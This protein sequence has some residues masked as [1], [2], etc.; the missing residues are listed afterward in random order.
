V[1]V[2]FAAFS[3]RGVDFSRISVLGSDAQELSGKTDYID[4]K[5]LGYRGDPIETGGRFGKLLFGKKQK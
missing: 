3:R 2:D 1:G 4:F 5:S